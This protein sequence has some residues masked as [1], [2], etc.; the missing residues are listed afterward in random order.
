MKNKKEKREK[1]K[2]RL[3]E[4]VDGVHHVMFQKQPKRTDRRLMG[5]SD[6]R[7]QR[8][9]SISLSCRVCVFQIF[10]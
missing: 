10:F 3:G 5:R 8:E 7:T 1:K 6:T 9:Y 2:K 4:G